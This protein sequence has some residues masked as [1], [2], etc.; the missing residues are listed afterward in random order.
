M[1]DIS[2]IKTRAELA[3]AID[4]TATGGLPMLIL[5]LLSTAP[6]NAWHGSVDALAA[7][8]DWPGRESYGNSVQLSNAWQQRIFAA[9]P[10]LAEFGVR[11]RRGFVSRD[12]RCAELA[13]VDAD[14]FAIATAAAANI[15]EESEQP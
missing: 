12:G 15:P 11:V 13:V 8:V 2:L 7:A 6:E 10:A 5:D 1:T 9:A 3:H 4:G 14:A